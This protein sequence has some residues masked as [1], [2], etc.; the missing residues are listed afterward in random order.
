MTIKMRITTRPIKQWRV[1]RELRRRIKKTFDQR[2]I[3]IPYPHRTIYI[4]HPKAASLEPL[5]VKL[6]REIESAFL[7]QHEEPG[8]K[9][10]KEDPRT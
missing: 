4:G 7:A 5:H 6:E 9:D 8:R 3:E 10:E 2:G 1:A